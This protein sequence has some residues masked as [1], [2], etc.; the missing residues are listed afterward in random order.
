MAGF[1]ADLPQA[2]LEKEVGEFIKFD[3]GTEWKLKGFYVN[4]LINQQYLLPHP[5]G[6]DPRYPGRIVYALA[7]FTHSEKSAILTLLRAA[8]EAAKA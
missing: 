7:R 8:Q 3:D 4:V 6:S 1:L 2:P 5:D